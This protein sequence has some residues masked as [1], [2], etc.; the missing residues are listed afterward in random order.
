MRKLD[1]TFY[2]ELDELRSHLGNTE[3][4]R[5][6]S[7]PAVIGLMRKYEVRDSDLMRDAANGILDNIEKAEDKAAQ[8]DAKSGQLNL[9]PYATQIALGGRNRIKRGWANFEQLWRRKRVIDKNKRDQ[10]RAWGAESSWLD[11]K[12]E[13]LKGHDSATTVR[14]VAPEPVP[15]STGAKSGISP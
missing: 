9:F 15:S 5:D 7:L 10:D 13:L 3:Y 11:D 12:M 2:R 14:D 8:V 1:S 4:N 6:Q